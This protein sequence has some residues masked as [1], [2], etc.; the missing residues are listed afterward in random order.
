MKDLLKL[1]FLLR[2]TNI[3]SN[4]GLWCIIIWI[5]QSLRIF[6][7]E[8]LYYACIFILNGVSCI[9]NGGEYTCLFVMICL[10]GIGVNFLD[11][12]RKKAP[13]SPSVRLVPSNQGSY[14][15]NGDE[16]NYPF[17]KLKFFV[18]KI[19]KL[20]ICLILIVVCR[21]VLY[22]AFRGYWNKKL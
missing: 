22:T 8:F 7:V 20:L 21:S 1:F 2:Y 19:K 4:E 6:L 3:F 9:S 11:N 14:N 18:E 15:Y 10:V 16:Q 13:H 12:L 17:W 5:I